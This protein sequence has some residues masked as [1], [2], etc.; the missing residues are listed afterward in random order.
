MGECLRV[1][2]PVKRS[3]KQI[4]IE[5]M[6]VAL[7]EAGAKAAELSGGMSLV[8]SEF[9]T[10]LL[11]GI[12]G[13]VSTALV[14]FKM[15]GKIEAKIR[16][17][18]DS[19]D[20]YVTQKQCQAHRCA[21]EKRIDEIGPALHRLFMKLCDIDKKSEERSIRLHDRLEP[22]ISKVAAN[23]EAIDIMKREKFSDEKRNA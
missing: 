20:L 16:R 15:K 10:A 22:V 12:A 11:T 2:P 13:V 7:T 19:D 8:S 17:P 14:Y 6:L 18:L 23:S 21:L 3:Q 9:I 1:A 5:S 4:K